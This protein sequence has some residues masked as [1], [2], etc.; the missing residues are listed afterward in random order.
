[1][2]LKSGYNLDSIN[3]FKIWIQSRFYKCIQNLDTIWIALITSEHMFITV[4]MFTGGG[5]GQLCVCR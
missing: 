2:Y 1:M 3:V 5:G 4:H